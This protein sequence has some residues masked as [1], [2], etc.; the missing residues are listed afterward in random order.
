[1]NNFQKIEEINGDFPNFEYKRKYFGEIDSQ[2][3]FET[4]QS[5]KI[6]N[7]SQKYN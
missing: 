3:T 4:P 6:G 2:A 7:M 1:M 5:S